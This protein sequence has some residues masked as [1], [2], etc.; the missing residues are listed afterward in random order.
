MT[1]PQINATLLRVTS[2]AGSEDFDRDPDDG[3]EVWAGEEGVY[4]RE[5]RERTFGETSDILLRR[6]LIVP[7]GL[8]DWAAGDV[9]TFRKVIGGEQQGRVQMIEAAS[10]PGLPDEVQTTRLTLEAA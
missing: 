1:F 5:K 6:T 9:V 7:T 3:D 10:L 2:G 4:Y 8:R